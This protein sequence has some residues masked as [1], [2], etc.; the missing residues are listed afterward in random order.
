MTHIIRLLMVSIILYSGLDAQTSQDPFDTV[1]VDTIIAD[2]YYDR[3]TSRIQSP[4]PPQ[5]INEDKQSS[6]PFHTIS[7]GPHLGYIHY[8][9]IFHENEMKALAL[10]DGIVIDSFAG[11]PKSTEYGFCPGLSF[12][13]CYTGK[14]VPIFFSI[15]TLT[16]LLGVGNTYD[17]ST[18]SVDSTSSG[19][20]A[21]FNPYT[22][23]KTN[24]YMRYGFDLGYLFI[25]KKF[26]LRISTGFEQRIWRRNLVDRS[27]IPEGIRVKDYERYSWISIPVNTVLYYLAN[28]KFT[29]GAEFGTKFMV[30]GK[31][32]IVFSISNNYEKIETEADAVKLG[33]RVGCYGALLLEPRISR[34][35]GL[36]IAPYFEY[37]RFGKSNTGTKRYVG[38]IV[39]NEPTH[40]YEPASKT[41][42]GGLAFDILI[43]PGVKKQ[44]GF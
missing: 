42:W 36:R 16:L 21:E 33:N 37:Y 41:F 24:L 12:S 13:Y 18:G 9:E 43:Y 28:D 32:Q 10:M 40:F 20:V 22:F 11:V 1:A 14:K 4:V 19:V 27:D 2:S 8:D 35:V 44:S 25:V 26:H 31:M 15:P 34:K 3:T 29:I 38:N 5:Q 23:T 7:L 39:N 17:G 30:Y 6:Y